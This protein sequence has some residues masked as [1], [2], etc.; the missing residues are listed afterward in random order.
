VRDAFVYAPFEGSWYIVSNLVKR[1]VAQD[2]RALRQ[3]LPVGRRILSGGD[4]PAASMRWEQ[5]DYRC[6][7]K[8]KIARHGSF[9]LF[10][11]P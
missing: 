6:L 10:L 5:N 1:G 9:S 11:Y 3:G 4:K 7:F 2:W 8:G